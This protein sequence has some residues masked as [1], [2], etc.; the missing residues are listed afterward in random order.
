LAAVAVA[1]ATQVVPLGA[2]AVAYLEWVITAAWQ[3]AASL[4]AVVV[5][6]LARQVETLL[7]RQVERLAAEQQTQ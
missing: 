3:L 4:A 6:V 2:L 1:M 5:V 7:L